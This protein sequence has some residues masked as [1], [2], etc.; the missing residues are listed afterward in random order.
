[1]FLQLFNFNE[2]DMVDVQFILLHSLLNLLFL[3]LLLVL[4]LLLL[5]HLP[6]LIYKS[7]AKTSS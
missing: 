7:Y 6:S 2:I 1:M 4:R 3:L 5:P